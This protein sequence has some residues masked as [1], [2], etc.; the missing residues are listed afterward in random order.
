MKSDFY[1][2]SILKEYILFIAVA[3][4]DGIFQFIT[5]E[6]TICDAIAMGSRIRTLCISEKR[7]FLIIQ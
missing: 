5:K 1:Y 4:F 3:I 7:F 2:Q 6:E